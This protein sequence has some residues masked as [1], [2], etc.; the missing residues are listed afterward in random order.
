[1][2]RATSLLLWFLV[3]EGL[4][5]VLV[6][7]RQSTELI[8]G[9]AAAAIGAAFAE[10]LRSRGLLAYAVDPGLLAKAW[11]LPWLVPFDFAVVTW[12]LV[13]SLAR[14]RRVRGSWVTV[15][16][17]TEP[18]PRGRWQR[19]FGTTLANG[20]PNALPV[21]LRGDEALMHA[22]APGVF[23]ARTVL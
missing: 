17:P 3:L 9:L 21:E 4:W 19:A 5:A 8:A 23:S 2:R 6:G 11:K 13:R 7:T 12:V 22:L 10:V 20:A 14:G 1:V 18:G 15:P 16:F